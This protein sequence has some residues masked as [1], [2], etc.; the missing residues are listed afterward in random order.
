MSMQIPDRGQVPISPQPEIS[1]PSGKGAKSVVSL[2]Q[3]LK[4][5]SAEITLTPRRKIGENLHK[6][7]QSPITSSPAMLAAITMGAAKSALLEAL[8]QQ[9]PP[10][11]TTPK[12]AGA[13]ERS[14]KVPDERPRSHS[15][16]EVPAKSPPPPPT[17][18]ELEANVAKAYRDKGT[19][20]TPKELGILREKHANAIKALAEAKKKLEAG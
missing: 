4:G 10:E 15:A 11:P 8:K 7:M 3:Q 14:L 18:A 5:I 19:A 6:L 16:S 9:G 17:I 2:P 13:G 12:S 20:K 1:E